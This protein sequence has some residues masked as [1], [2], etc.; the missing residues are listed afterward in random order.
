M[1]C[2]GCGTARSPCCAR[3]AA[4]G[5]VGAL[6]T[7]RSDGHI[8]S[9]DEAIA[10]AGRASFAHDGFNV[11]QSTIATAQGIGAALSTSLAG[12]VVVVNTGYN[13]A[14]IT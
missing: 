10:G 12:L 14:F 4:S 11:S 3:G 9:A 8:K 6:P 13:A 5:C 2:N 1:S 7:A